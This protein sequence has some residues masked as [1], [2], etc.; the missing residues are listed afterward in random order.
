M[1]N[2][3]YVLRFNSL[4]H[5]MVVYTECSIKYFLFRDDIKSKQTWR[6]VGDELNAARIKSSNIILIQHILSLLCSMC[7][8]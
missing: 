4:T 5:T 6:K 1:L 8:C 3:Y 7:I 2:K